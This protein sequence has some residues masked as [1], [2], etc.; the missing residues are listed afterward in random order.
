MAERTEADRPTRETDARPTVTIPTT[1]TDAAPIPSAS[2]PEHGEG[3]GAQTFAGL[4]HLT[5]PPETLCSE[6]SLLAAI[7]ALAENAARSA[8]GQAT[9]ATAAEALRDRVVALL[10]SRLAEGRARV[11]AALLASPAAG[12]RVARAYSHVT[13][14]IVSAAAHFCMTH[15]H[16][17]PV[18]TR[19]E[20]LAVVAVGGYGR[21]EMAP[22][23]DVDL[24]FL[25]PW[26]R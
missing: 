20:Q 11:D 18:R 19:A 5:E 25:T 3:R 4:A 26:K 12:L 16:P 6:R 15:L 17:A 24:L 10:A 23:S 22:Y 8:S 13:D 7:D 2:L 14:V 1:D 9:A 21:G